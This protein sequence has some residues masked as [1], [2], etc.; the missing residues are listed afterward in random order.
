ML[1]IEG[2]ADFSCK[3]C[4]RNMAVGAFM[5][6]RGVYIMRVRKAVLQV[7]GQPA[8]MFIVNL[9]HPAMAFR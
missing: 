6:A 5:L 9:S 2:G 7:G 8:Y 4:P 3:R 1:R